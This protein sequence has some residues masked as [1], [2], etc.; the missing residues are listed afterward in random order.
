[1]DNPQQGP[2]QPLL[3]IR[4]E[5]TRIS[6]RDPGRQRRHPI[7]QLRP[8]VRWTIGFCVWHAAIRLKDHADDRKVW[9]TVLGTTEPEMVS[10]LL[11]A[12][13]ASNDVD[14]LR[15]L[16]D[17]GA[18]FADYDGVASGWEE[19]KVAHQKFLDAGYSLELSDSI[20]LQADDVALVHWSWAVTR[21]DGASI[22]GA[23]A[24]VLRRQVDG[25]W[26]F[27]IDNSD[28]SALIA[29]L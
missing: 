1:M 2:P 16:Y 6:D 8:Y 15:E 19:I 10:K 9:S 21:P 3:L 4:V 18:V 14:G 5:S 28:G 25:T 11:E 27:I 22:E 29:S 23:S 13:L 17:E 24:E 20:T 26:R 7:Q 12:C